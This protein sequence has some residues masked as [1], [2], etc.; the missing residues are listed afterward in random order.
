MTRH[1]RAILVAL[2]VLLTLGVAAQQAGAVEYFWKDATGTLEENKDVTATSG[3]TSFKIRSSLAGGAKFVVTCTGAMFVGGAA[4]FNGESRLKRRVGRWQAELEL[5]GCSSTVCSEVVGGKIKIPLVGNSDGAIISD[6]KM[7]SEVTR[8][9]VSFFP[10]GSEFTKFTL[11]EGTCGAGG[12]EVPITTPF[13]KRGFGEALESEG[14]LAIE[15]DAGLA[16]ATTSKLTH[17]LSFSCSGEAQIP[18]KGFNTDAEEIKVGD[19]KY[20]TRSACIEGKL[21]LELLSKEEF[22]LL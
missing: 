22:R 17:K 9:L 20:A 7:E 14:G 10:S 15:V 13:T 2:T 8:L 3:G 11:K 6:G 19:L 12:V 21:T 1:G 5:T 18:E 16:E 4:I